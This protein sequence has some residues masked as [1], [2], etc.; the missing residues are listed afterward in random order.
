MLGGWFTWGNGRGRWSS[1]P[2]TWGV[3]TNPCTEG[4]H[5]RMLPP[6]LWLMPLAYN[7]SRGAS[8]GNGKYSSPGT[9]RRKGVCGMQR[10]WLSR[11]ERDAEALSLRGMR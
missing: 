5:L 4:T 7:L 3:H 2:T 10:S 1:I 6:H 8:I 9:N 11:G